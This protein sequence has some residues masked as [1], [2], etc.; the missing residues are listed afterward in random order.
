MNETAI[1][2]SDTTNGKPPQ[3]VD[4]LDYDLPDELIA[5]HP[6]AQ[7]DGSRMLC[8]DRKQDSLIDGKITDLPTRL[9]LGDL[10]VLNDTKVLPAKLLARRE[11]GGRVGGLF[12][13]ETEPG[14]W[15]VMLTGSRRLRP[16][17]QL[18]LDVDAP[19][20]LQLIESLGDGRW[21]VQVTGDGSTEAILNRVGHVP[22][23]PYIRRN[24]DGD[25][26]SSDDRDRYQTVYAHAAGAIAAPTAGLHL[27]NELLDRIRKSGVET[28]TL[29]LHVGSGTFQP[30]R[31]NEL[32]QHTMHM[33]SYHIEPNVVDAIRRC[34]ETGGR[35]I[36]VG[37]TSVRALESAA[38][39]N[40]AAPLSTGD[41]TTSIFIRPPYKFNVV[42]G[43]VTNFHLPKS[44][45]LALV[46]ALG[47]TNRIRR[48]YD[49]AVAKRYRF[50]SYGDAMLI[51]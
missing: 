51:L 48:A 10:L 25:A 3:T 30:I 17:E 19:E 38:T 29:T 11:T 9:K 18:T 36:A 50:F 49:H 13:R 1:Q 46:M 8:V 24:R 40:G 7:R 28:V 41:A 15:I 5:Q 45:L 32:A 26:R 12:E 16:G 43:L 39:D 14:E 2:P 35:V 20:H 47:G 42:D 23:P 31:V 27:T 6:L 4:D 33:E 44:T 37:T 22:L 21:R 34:R